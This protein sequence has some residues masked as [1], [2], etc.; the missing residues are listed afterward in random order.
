MFQKPPLSSPIRGGSASPSV[1]TL[2][3]A[4]QKFV[5]NAIAKSSRS[6]DASCQ[7]SGCEPQCRDSKSGKELDKVW[8]R[9]ELTAMSS[10]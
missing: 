7:P 10:S 9:W 1:R 4:A 8:K 6:V 3:L 5:R 2:S